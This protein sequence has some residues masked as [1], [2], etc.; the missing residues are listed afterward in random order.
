MLDRAWSVCSGMEKP[1]GEGVINRGMGGITGNDGMVG[2][3][4][5]CVGA[6]LCLTQIFRTDSTLTH[7]TIQVIQL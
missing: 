2:G 3:S 6:E 4:L 5:G 7:V 1:P